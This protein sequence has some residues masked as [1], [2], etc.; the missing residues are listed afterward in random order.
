MQRILLRAKE[1]EIEEDKG[2]MEKVKTEL[3]S[4]MNLLDKTA[5]DEKDGTAAQWEQVEKSFRLVSKA[6][7][8]NLKNLKRLEEDVQR[9]AQL[10]KASLD[11]WNGDPATLQSWILHLKQ[12]LKF[13]DGGF[14][15]VQP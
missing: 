9:R 7:K 10:P 11:T 14:S 4:A 8:M 5:V 15:I 13:S 2:T 6:Q 1:N 12:T 3:T